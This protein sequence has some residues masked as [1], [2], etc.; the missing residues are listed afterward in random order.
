MISSTFNTLNTKFNLST[1]NK[2]SP[3]YKPSILKTEKTETETFNSYLNKYLDKDLDFTKSNGLLSKI[4]INQKLSNK[5]KIKKQKFIDYYQQKLGKE[6]NQG[7]TK[8]DQSDQIKDLIIDTSNSEDEIEN[9]FSIPIPSLNKLL[10]NSNSTIDSTYASTYF[11]PST[12]AAP[13]PKLVI[14]KTINSKLIDMG[15]AGIDD[16]D[17]TEDL[18][19]S[20]AYNLYSKMKESLSY[21]NESKYIE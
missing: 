10:I 8:K 3:E 19:F 16:E 17:D 9:P 12:F 5:L 11:N 1:I 2:Y 13:K 7:F 15:F 21:K 20:T 6:S 4:L 18:H 14:E